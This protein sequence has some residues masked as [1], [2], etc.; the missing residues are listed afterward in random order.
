MEARGSERKHT[1]KFPLNSSYSFG[2]ADVIV[3]VVVV[4][5]V[6][7]GLLKCEIGGF[8]SVNC[9]YAP[10]NVGTDE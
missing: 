5:V 6:N 4:V 9:S 8:S 10:L 1:N 2:T 7:V 3:V